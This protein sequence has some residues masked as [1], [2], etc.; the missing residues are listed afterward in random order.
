MGTYRSG[1]NALTGGRRRVFGAAGVAGAALAGAALPTLGWRAEPAAAAGDPSPLPKPIPGGFP[2]QGGVIH[3]FAPG[4]EGFTLPF[5][6]GQLQGLDVENSVL[7]DFKGA[8]ALAYLVGTATGHDGA[9][10]DLETDLRAFEGE[11]VAA[12]GQRRRGTFALV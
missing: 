12:N 3:V 9:S 4:P 11:Y 6:R 1:W 5:S 8:S 7:T 2:L 10:Y